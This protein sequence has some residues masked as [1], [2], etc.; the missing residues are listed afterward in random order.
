[1]QWT[2]EENMMQPLGSLCRS[3]NDTIEILRQETKHQISGCNETNRNPFRCELRLVLA[4]LLK[5]DPERHFH[6]SHSL[7]CLALGLC[8]AS[9]H[10]SVS[11][12]GSEELHENIARTQDQPEGKIAISSKENG[13]LGLKSKTPLATSPQTLV[14]Q[15]S[16]T[17]SPNQDHWRT[18]SKSTQVILKKASTMVNWR[19]FQIHQLSY[20]QRLPDSLF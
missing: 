19:Y 5:A 16:C 14:Q 2:N 13:L 20:Q 9:S 8:S 3:H 4:S 10:A 12:A 11:P 18:C 1:M 7:I 6:C 17:Q 15:G